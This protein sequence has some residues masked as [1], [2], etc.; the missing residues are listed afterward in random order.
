MSWVRYVRLDLLLCQVDRT[1]TC[2]HEGGGEGRGDGGCFHCILFLSASSEEE[3]ASFGRLRFPVR[4][5][6]DGT[7]IFWLGAEAL[8]LIS[9]RLVLRENAAAYPFGFRRDCE[10]QPLAR[11]AGDQSGRGS[12][13]GEAAVIPRLNHAR[14]LIS[15]APAGVTAF[16]SVVRWLALPAIFRC[17]YRRRVRCPC[18]GVALLI[19][20]IA[21]HV[22]LL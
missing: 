16:A 20:E 9:A 11:A 12:R 5:P 2:P 6:T 3:G 13:P 7:K 10:I 19:G 14:L 4:I 22:H 1:E 15:A 21:G 8:L 17:R 18:R